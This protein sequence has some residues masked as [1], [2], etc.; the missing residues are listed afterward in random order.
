MLD[1]LRKADVKF[2]IKIKVC[3]LHLQITQTGPKSCLN[4]SDVQT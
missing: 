3:G 2:H 4:D 1:F